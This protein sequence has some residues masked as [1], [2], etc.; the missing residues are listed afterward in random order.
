M[1]MKMGVSGMN[2][3][4]KLHHLNSLLNVLNMHMRMA[5]VGILVPV[6]KL[7][8]VADTLIA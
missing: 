1:H 4:V 5:A 2:V 6:Q 7:L 3:L 8:K